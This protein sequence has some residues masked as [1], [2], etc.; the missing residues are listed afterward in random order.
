M[1]AYAYAYAYNMCWEVVLLIVALFE[2]VAHSFVS[3]LSWNLSF[4]VYYME[5][6]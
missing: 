2:A 4:V 1:H 6:N 5:T 3:L